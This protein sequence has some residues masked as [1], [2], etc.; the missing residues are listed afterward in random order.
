LSE[1]HF[2]NVRQISGDFANVWQNEFRARP[3]DLPMFGK[4]GPVLPNIG[5]TA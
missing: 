4:N 3:M 1:G 5:K 2:A